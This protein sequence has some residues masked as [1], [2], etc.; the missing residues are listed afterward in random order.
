MAVIL[1]TFSNAFSWMKILYFDPN[2]IEI[3]PKGVINNHL[4]LIQGLA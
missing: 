2:L 3:I 1:L 4:S